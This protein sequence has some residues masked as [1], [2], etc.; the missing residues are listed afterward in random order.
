M[1]GLLES[2]GAQPSHAPR[3]KPIHVARM[4]TG[5]F[6]NRN[7]LH[8]SA[9]YVISRFYG[10]Y[11][12]A[13]IDGSNMEVSN[14]LTLIRRP[15]LSEWSNQTIP[16][17]PNRF[18][19]FASRLDGV[20]DVIV[21]TPVASIWATPTSKTTIFTKSSGAGQGYY[22]GVGNTLYYGDG[23]DLQKWDGTNV[24]N[25]GIVAP[26]AAPA[27]TITETGT[28]G[29]AAS[30]TWN[31]STVFSTMG[32]LVDA[33]G[34]V[35][36]LLGVN[37]NGSQIGETGNGEPTWNQ[38]PGG[39]TTDNGWNWTNW[40]PIVAWGPVKTFNNASVGGTTVNPCIV[41]DPRTKCCFINIA[42]SNAQ[43]TSGNSYPNF[44]S[45]Y[46]Q[47][48][49]DGT[50]KWFNIT[51]PSGWQPS[52]TYIP[53]GT[54]DDLHC[55]IVEPIDLSNGLPTNQTVYWQMNDTGSNQ[56]SGTGGT[57]PP[58]NTIV[59]TT[60][61]DNQLTWLCL[62]S[63]TRQTNHTYTSWTQSG[64]VFSAIKDSN[65]NM[66]VCIV[67][68]V[69]SA[70][71]TASISWATGYGQQTSD[72]SVTWVC[73][74]QSSSWAANTNWYLSP[75]GFFPPQ[76]SVP[77][78]GPSVTDTNG[79]VQF[80]INSGKTGSSQPSWQTPGNNTT[81]GT[82]T[83]FCLASASSFPGSLSWTKGYQYAVSFSSRAANDIYNTATPPGWTGPLGTPTGAQSGHVSTASPLFTISG[84]N[85]G[86]I[87]TLSGIGSTDPQV[88]TIIIWRTLDGGSDLFF[89]TEIPNPTPIGGI[90]QKWKYVD[91]QLDTT[92]NELISAPIN[93]SNDP[94]PAG[95][96][97]MAYHFERVWGAVG[98]FVYCSGGPD[99]VTGNP[100]ES[101]NPTNFFEF[102]AAVVRILP[103]ATGIL[104]FTISDVYAIMGGPIFATF[105]PSPQ[106]PGVGLLNYNAL[107][108]HGGVIYM[109]TADKQL[110]SL[111]P[112][113]GAS[114]I[115]GGIADKLENFDPT[116]AFV[117]VH[118][119]GNDNCIIISDGSTGWYRLNPNQFPN[120]NAVWS[121]F[122][123]ITNGAGAVQ[124]IQVSK[125][126]HR[127]LVGSPSSN[128]KI[129]QRDF[130]TYTDDGTPYTC[131]F[132]MGSINL[133]NPGQIA[134]LTFINVRAKKVGTA[135]TVGFLLNEINGTFT[136][137]TTSHP[138]PWEIYGAAGAPTSLYSNAY[139]FRETAVPAYAE[140]LL[141]QVAFPA[142]NFANE[143]LTLTVWGVIGE[144]EEI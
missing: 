7:A 140:H 62:G 124:S 22:Q 136:N 6:T 143:V 138:Y 106:I 131:F 139:Y 56:T 57:A 101:F 70:T 72:G 28:S 13:L 39:T 23:V 73:V 37:N 74:G 33:N 68:G 130:S 3:G 26:N 100:N 97:P 90:A 65:N 122:A 50:A 32:L 59:G 119:S 16:N 11:V 55:A 133:V 76:G 111:D 125:G 8:D 38:T 54:G 142:E 82:A 51:R 95:F 117:T 15:G 14:Q 41:Y 2:A 49:Y 30:A 43:G 24:W 96:K 19:S 81:D 64:S 44:P 123:T 88:D 104:V 115:G 4:E 69:S 18:Y 93:E 10:G 40:G 31:P 91:Y 58:W 86:A 61:K 75:S 110:I 113:G 94:P 80:I 5:L 63:A 116:A 112:S 53:L 9:Q 25:W 144:P 36:Q 60:T 132:T 52:H 103:T 120:G 71:T 47:I 29:S 137:F 127:L 21:D 12:D 128:G 79:N 121:P 42:P 126:V 17:A 92:V 27:V 98:N 129:L 118:E 48:V 45:G 78:G 20:V 46:T 35:Q 77:Y 109:F 102:P 105:F 134:G 85:P 67:G 66:Q 141:V 108:V 84:G 87:N 114:R 99:T 89:L 135:P 107:D 34:N 83:W 1:A